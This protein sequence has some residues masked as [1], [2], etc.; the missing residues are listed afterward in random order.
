LSP[1]GKSPSKKKSWQHRQINHKTQKHP[2]LPGAQGARLTR[3][4]NRAR[5]SPQKQSQETVKSDDQNAYTDQLQTAKI[6]GL[7]GAR[8]A[9]RRRTARCDPLESVKKKNPK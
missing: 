2:S 9:R 8:T 6:A 1:S 3:A 5:C 7:Q 4:F